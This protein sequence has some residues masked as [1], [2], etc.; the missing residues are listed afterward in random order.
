MSVETTPSVI[1]VTVNALTLPQPAADVLAALSKIAELSIE[2]KNS[3]ILQSIVDRYGITD[4][5]K[6]SRIRQ[7]WDAF[8][9]TVDSVA[10]SAEAPSISA[11]ASSSSMDAIERR[12]KHR[13]DAVKGR[14]P[15]QT[16]SMPQLIP[17]PDDPRGKRVVVARRANA[18][19]QATAGTH[20][21]GNIFN[22]GHARGLRGGGQ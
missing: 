18:D 9:R 3:D 8:M 15:G 4:G 10:T 6:I 1:V 19:P 21:A 2:D 7:A 17:A 14:L 16:Q 12:R 5:E 13:D 11:E 20:D 22:H